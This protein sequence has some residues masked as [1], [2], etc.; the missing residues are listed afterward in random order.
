V[1]GSP[2]TLHRHRKFAVSESILIEAAL[3]SFLESS[4]CR[5]NRQPPFASF[6]LEPH[7]FLSHFFLYLTNPF[8]YMRNLLLHLTAG[9]CM[10]VFFFVAGKF[11]WLQKSQ[12]RLKKTGWFLSRLPFGFLLRESLSKSLFLMA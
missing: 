9:C 8:S 10:C 4:L 11:F 3:P 2:H 7:H 12:A 6:T 1:F 5:E